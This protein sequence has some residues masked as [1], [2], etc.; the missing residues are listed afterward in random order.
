MTF[1]FAL[2]FYLTEQETSVWLKR[3]NTPV[4]ICRFC[5]HDEVR[6]NASAA[7]HTH[8]HTRSVVPSC[9]FGA[10]DQTAVPVAWTE[11]A[12]WWKDTI[13]TLFRGLFPSLALPLSRVLSGRPNK[14]HWKHPTLAQLATMSM[15]IRH[16]RAHM[17]THTQTTGTNA[18]G[19]WI[20]IALVKL[21]I[22]PSQC[23]DRFINGLFSH[24]FRR[25]RKKTNHHKR[26]EDI[27]ELTQ[28]RCVDGLHGFLHLIENTAV[29]V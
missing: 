10:V 19:R 9:S 16:T 23:L 22:T 12:V 26:S 28:T 29:H 6:E 21:I 7:T 18:S 24:Y 11:L 5:N 20:I 3:K 2:V 15:V 1:A 27:A 4:Y 13:S 25:R 14:G 17:R 8:T